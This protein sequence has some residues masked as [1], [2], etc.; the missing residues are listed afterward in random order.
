MNFKSPPDTP[1]E[2]A[3]TWFDRAVD[4]S[5]T[6]NPLSMVLT[7]VNKDG[8]PS[9]RVVLQKGFDSNG[10]LFFTNYQSDKANDISVNKTVSLLFYR[11][12]MQLQLQIQGIATKLTSAES[13]AYFATRSRISQVGAWASNQSKP[14]KSRTALMAKVVTLTAKWIGRKIPRP[15]HWG[16]YRV[17]LDM[18]EFLEVKEGRLH[19]RIRYINQDGWSYKLL[20]P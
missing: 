19:N 14:L 11:D 18:I 2:S 9:S 16:G 12:D 20:Q 17:S 15:E 3:Q 4:R 6:P 13:D 5:S 10:L 8:H 1:I 7:T